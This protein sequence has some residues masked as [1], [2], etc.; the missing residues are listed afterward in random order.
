MQFQMNVLDDAPEM[1]A[2]C[3]A[4]NQA[5]I[6]RGPL[7]MGLLTGKYSTG[8]A[9]SADDVRG[10]KSPGWMKYFRNGQPNPEWSGKLDAIREIL[11]SEGRSLAQGA[12]CWLWA[13]SPQTLP[14]P[15]FRTVRQVEENAGALQFAPLTGDQMREID[16]LLG[17]I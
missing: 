1:V 11:T 7:A 13:R 4:L 12:L 17:R 8:A 3:E 15:G 6:N 16:R 9:I 10:D 14:I 2:L 5:G